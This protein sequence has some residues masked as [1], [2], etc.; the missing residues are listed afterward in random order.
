MSQS[1]TNATFAR[2]EDLQKQWQ[3]IRDKIACTDP[4]NPSAQAERA[5]LNAQMSQITCQMA[6][7]LSETRKAIPTPDID[8]SPTRQSFSQ[9]VKYSARHKHIICRTYSSSESEASDFAHLTDLPGGQQMSGKT[10]ARSTL[11]KNIRKGVHELGNLLRQ[12]LRPEAPRAETDDSLSDDAADLTIEQSRLQREAR[13]LRKMAE[14]TAEQEQR[15]AVVTARLEQISETLAA[16]DGS[17][18]ER[19]AAP[20][21]RASS[22]AADAT[23]TRDKTNGKRKMG[24]KSLE[25]GVASF[26]AQV[27]SAR[28]TMSSSSSPRE[29][30]PTTPPTSPPT[31]TTVRRMKG[32]P[33]SGGGSAS[34]VFGNAADKLEERGDKLAGAAM[35]TERMAEDAG[36]MLAAARALR[37]RKQQRGFFG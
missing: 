4:N 20:S 28:N 34:N 33:Q 11:E 18:R 21:A 8:D 9:P 23:E 3:L 15:L 5:T 24:W 35:E 31:L 10:E 37:Q 14:R 25:A 22:A 6:A 16:V 30:K 12:K 36:D 13:K 1:S 32:V 27:R 17:S 19:L 2:S 29:S 26:K 7:L